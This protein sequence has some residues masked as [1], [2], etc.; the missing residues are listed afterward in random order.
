MHYVDICTEN[1]CSLTLL[2]LTTLFLL[3]ATLL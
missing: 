2:L 1:A 3:L